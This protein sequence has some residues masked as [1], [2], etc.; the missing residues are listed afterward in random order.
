MHAGQSFTSS[1]VGSDEA[2]RGHVSRL[3]SDF[4]VG[5]GGPF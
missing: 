3:S 2:V 4:A 1:A 5:D